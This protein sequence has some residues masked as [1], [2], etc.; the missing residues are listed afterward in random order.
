MSEN[1]KYPCENCSQKETTVKSSQTY[2]TRLAA[3]ADGESKA[4]DINTVIF[5]E[6]FAYLNPTKESDFKLNYV[7]PDPLDYRKKRTQVFRK[8][9]DQSSIASNA[10]SEYKATF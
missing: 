9:Y 4:K 3:V 10:L 2:S 8:T 7:K 6:R 5:N 1:E